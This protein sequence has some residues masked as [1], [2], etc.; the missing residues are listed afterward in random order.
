MTM[1]PTLVAKHF[2]GA[3]DVSGIDYFTLEPRPFAVGTVGLDSSDQDV[4]CFDSVSGIVAYRNG[5]VLTDALNEVCYQAISDIS[6]LPIFPNLQT[7]YAL[8]LM[9]ALSQSRRLKTG[10]RPDYSPL[11]KSLSL[12]RPR[13]VA[14]AEREIEDYCNTRSFLNSV[15]ARAGL[16]FMKDGRLNAQ[17]FPG[18]QAYDQ[19]YRLMVA[20][21]V[22]SVGIAKSGQ[23]LEV[24]R[25]YAKT[26]RKQVG[27]R[28]FAIRIEREHLE[29][30]HPGPRSNPGLQKTLRHGSA[31][32]AL[33]GVGAIRYAL[34]ISG[35]ELCLVE[36][37]L[38]D[39][40][41]FRSLIRRGCSLEQWA[42]EMF[43]PEKRAIHSW[44]I[45][46]FVTDNDCENLILPTLSEI[47]YAANTETE[48]R[49][50][51]RALANAHNRV[52]L[53]HA[54]LE[55]TRRQLIVDLAREGITPN[56]IPVTAEDPHKTDPEIVNQDTD[57]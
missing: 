9:L 51:P 10:Y 15:Y 32:A 43:G 46:G 55:M 42:Q 22:K 44:D 54:D 21:S 49:L 18:P 36:F 52:K 28:P 37:N 39:L 1:N 31:S 53:R 47:V 41:H 29:I 23:V 40:Q 50:Y 3:S 11:Q 14:A 26:I 13:L 19:I 33:G 24:V 38:Y 16:L 12:M 35:E 25:P 4:F 5:L 7:D 27:D 20:R 2:E 6:V 30:A 56:M 45:F 57:Y 34:S 48:I 17:S 8:R